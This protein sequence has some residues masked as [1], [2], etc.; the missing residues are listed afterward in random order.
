MEC[1]QAEDDWFNTIYMGLAYDR[2]GTEV[3]EWSYWTENVAS[4]SSMYYGAGSFYQEGWLDD[5]V[6][7]ATF[8]VPENVD[9][10]G[11]FVWASLGDP[12]DPEGETVVSN[13]VGA[14]ED[15]WPPWMTALAM[16][17][18]IFA[19]LIIA[20]NAVLWFLYSGAFGLGGLWRLRS[21]G[22]NGP[23]AMGEDARELDGW[24][25][26]L[27][28]DEARELAARIREVLGETE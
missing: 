14:I 4:H 19:T 13:G 27:W 1:Q 3:P 26:G 24:R 15:P 6:R 23:R 21:I 7:R 28:L 12:D 18:T 2:S 17:L 22:R 11:L 20:I 8:V 10:E 16:L 5:G 25:V 9:D